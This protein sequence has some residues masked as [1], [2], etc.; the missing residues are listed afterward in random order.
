MK[1]KFVLNCILFVALYQSVCGQTILREVYTNITGSSIANLTASEKF[2]YYP[3]LRTYQTNFEAP[4][5]FGDYYG[6]R[7][8]GYLIPPV[9]GYYSFWIASDDNSQLFLSTDESSYK[10]RLIAYV[11]SYT[12]SRQWDKEANQKSEPIYLEAGRRYYVEA[13][14]KEG[15][16]GDNLAVGCNCRT[17]L[18]ND[19]FPEIASNLM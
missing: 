5:S 13:L 12:S 6:T 16:G 14:H 10:T 4:T 19:L 11:N 15:A 9:P 2:P 17:G 8:R 18:L 3:D 7:M 1:G